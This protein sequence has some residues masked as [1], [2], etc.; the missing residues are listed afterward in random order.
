MHI[1]DFEYAL[2]ELTRVVKPNGY[3][4]LSEV[5]I[6]SI[7]SLFLRGLKRVLHRR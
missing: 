7:Q 4:V 2:D 1:P 3:L 5:N 6:Y